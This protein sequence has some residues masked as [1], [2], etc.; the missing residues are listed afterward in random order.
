[1]K[2]TFWPDSYDAKRN[3]YRACAGAC[4]LITHMT[5][6]EGSAN[7]LIGLTTGQIAIVLANLAVAIFGLGM[8]SGRLEIRKGF[9]VIVGCFLL[10]GS[11]TIAS[12]LVGALPANENL[13][14]REAPYESLPSTRAPL[15]F[16]TPSR[17][18]TRRGNPFDPY[19]GDQPTD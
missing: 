18:V 13:P 11:A 7:W 8:L 1:M 3:F 2:S 6:L 4:V 5:P 15:D 14:Y 12:T 17:P 19:S 10:L 9:Y 16:E